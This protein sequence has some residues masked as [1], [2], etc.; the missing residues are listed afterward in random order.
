MDV[1]TIHK[2]VKDYIN[3]NWT[4]TP[5]VFD[6]Y[7]AIEG[8]DAYIE[9]N[10]Q[11]GRVLYA[12]KGPVGV[13]IRTGS[14]SIVVRTP[15]KLG[16]EQLTDLVSGVEELFRRKLINGIDIDEPYS[17]PRGLEGIWSVYQTFVPFTAFV[18]E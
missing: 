8:K 10:T 13:G 7:T 2:T 12:E 9:V 15:S 3:T 4:Y 6:T 17:T 1:F 14:I 16:D 11:L 18:G 5:V